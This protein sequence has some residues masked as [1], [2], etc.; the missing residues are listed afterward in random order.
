MFSWNRRSTSD[1]YYHLRLGHKER[2]GD[3]KGPIACSLKS[4]SRSQEQILGKPWWT[5]KL[6]S[7]TIRLYKLSD[8]LVGVHQSLPPNTSYD[9]NLR[10]YGSEQLVTQSSSNH[11]SSKEWLS[12]SSS[13]F[14]ISQPSSSQFGAEMEWR[15]IEPC[16]LYC[17]YVFC[18]QIFSNNYLTRIYIT[19][20]FH[21][22]HLFVFTM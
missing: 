22:S 7:Q 19:I 9:G 14:S 2:L 10:T 3:F 12:L 6:Q 17:E 16:L 21:I 15:Y 20:P 18:G 1:A 8:I 4:K 13:Y 5:S 11:N